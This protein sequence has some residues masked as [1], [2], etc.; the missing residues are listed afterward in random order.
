MKIYD[1]CMLE[2]VSLSPDDTKLVKLLYG[3][4]FFVR[5]FFVVIF[6]SDL[7]SSFLEFYTRAGFGEMCESHLIRI[8]LE[9]WNDMNGVILCNYVPDYTDASDELFEYLTNLDR[10]WPKFDKDFDIHMDYTAYGESE[11][12]PELR[13]LAI[14]TL[15]SSGLVEFDE[16]AMS[17]EKARQDE[18]DAANRLEATK[19][20]SAKIKDDYS[21]V[22]VS[23]LD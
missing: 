23:F 10:K 9:R 11:K 8:P 20:Y 2:Q 16:D 22:D 3:V 17:K 12:T 7:D 15:N 14:R 4:R 19:E 6:E 18:I 5:R 21:K 13:L 1:E